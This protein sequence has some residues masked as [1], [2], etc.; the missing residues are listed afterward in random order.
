MDT[1]RARH[2]EL[3]LD[4]GRPL[5]EVIADKLRELVDTGVYKPGGKLPNESELAR[6]MRVARSSVR[7]ALQRL[8]AQRVLA[9]K[10]GLGWYVR[11]LPPPDAE[12][13]PSLFDARHY[14]ISDLF[15]MRIGLEGLAVS[16]AAFRASEGDVEDIAK[17][18]QLHLEAGE[19]LDE[20]L[21]TD[22]AFHGAIL[23]ASRNDLLIETYQRI[24]E[25]MREWRHQSFA[26]PGVPLRSA[27]EHSKVVRYLR[28][29]DP[30]G[31]RAAMNSHLQRLYDSLPDIP[32]E[33]LD[34]TV[35][36]LDAEPEWHLRGS[37]G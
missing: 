27:R 7:T 29:R 8:E 4:A 9:V 12:R 20:L 16:L 28:N 24:V 23:K 2:F 37:S 30:G 25:E 33:P 35:S 1:E 19:D 14:R 15:E 13:P 6:N 10:R 18:N 22:E 26:V 31:A 34:T 21:A 11:R 17:A 3:K 32:D 36:A 5:P